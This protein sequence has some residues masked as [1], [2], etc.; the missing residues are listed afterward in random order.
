MAEVEGRDRF[1]PDPF[2]H[3]DHDRIDEPEPERAILTANLGCAIEIVMA[4]VFDSKR[5]FSKI[6]EKRFLAASADL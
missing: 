6:H 1:R 5:A 3:C 2:G 4:A